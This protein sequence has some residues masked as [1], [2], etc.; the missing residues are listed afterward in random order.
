MGLSDGSTMSGMVNGESMSRNRRTAIV[1]AAG[2][3]KRMNSARAKVLHEVGG[4]PMIDRVLAMLEAA[5]IEAPVVVT[6]HLEEQVRSHLGEAARCVTQA[7]RKG[8]GHAVM[9]AEPAMA[10]FEGTV[11]VACGDVPLLRAET[12]REALEVFESRAAAGVVLTTELEDPAGYGRIMRRGGDEVERIVEHKD[13][14]EAERA[15][16]EINSGTYCFRSSA[17]FSALGEV[18][19][20]NA[21]GEYYL[22]DVVEILIRRGERVCAYKIA[23]PAEA[24][25]VNSP[26]ELERAEAALRD[27][28]AGI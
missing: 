2:E 22:T 3:G 15:V 25:G 11:V 27:R 4:R 1:L 23:D 14:S 24:M 13:A 26:E 10:G 19:N 28:G 16:R 20:D 21:Q 17:L 12:L 8:T 6:G 9:Q 5:G 7:E 18:K